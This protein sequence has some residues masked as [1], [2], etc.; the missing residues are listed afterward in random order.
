M[1]TRTCIRAVRVLAGTTRVDEP[2]GNPSGIVR[3]HGKAGAG[4]LGRRVRVVRVLDRGAPSTRPA[5]RRAKIYSAPGCSL[6]VRRRT[7][8]ARQ[9][10]AANSG[11]AA[12]VRAANQ[13]GIA[14][15]RCKAGASARGR[16][17][18]KARWRAEPSAL[19]R[20]R[21]K[22]AA[23]ALGRLVRETS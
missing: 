3:R 6:R 12:S 2:R 9:T 11:A 22:A 15:R 23:G 16:F 20:R 8:N 1:S 4:A 5:R 17:V 19:V 14:R 10:L 18:R 21:G 13:R 7:I